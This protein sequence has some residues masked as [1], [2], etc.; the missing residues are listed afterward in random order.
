[1]RNFKILLTSSRHWTDIKRISSTFEEIEYRVVNSNAWL[2]DFNGLELMHGDCPSGGDRPAG[3]IATDMGWKVKPIP[4]D[5]DHCGPMCPK[6]IGHRKVKKLND[7]DHPGLLEDFCPKAGPRRNKLMVSY[8]HDLCI[9]C[10][11][12]VSFGTTNCVKFAEQAGI[13]VVKYRG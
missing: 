7:I 6:P 5:W 2:T 8:G 12:S 9:A 3:K 4:A 10:F 1:M 11:L 13:R